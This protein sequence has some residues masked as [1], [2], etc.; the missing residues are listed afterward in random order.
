MFLDQQ[1]MFETRLAV[2]LLASSAMFATLPLRT[3]FHLQE[4]RAVR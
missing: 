2:I 4:T 3:V 1:L